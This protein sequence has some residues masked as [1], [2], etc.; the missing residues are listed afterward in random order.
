MI[1]FKDRYEYREIDDPPLPNLK[2]GWEYAMIY[3][4]GAEL[5]KMVAQ[6]QEILPMFIDESGKVPFAVMGDGPCPRPVVRAN[7]GEGIF[8]VWVVKQTEGHASREK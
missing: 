8:L 4:P 1:V 5:L 6:G 3:V 7:P 2:E